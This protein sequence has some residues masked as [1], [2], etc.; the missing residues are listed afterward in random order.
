M[1]VLESSAVQFRYPRSQ[2]R[3]VMPDLSLDAGRSLF[4]H[5]PSGSGKT[6]LLNLCAG[7]LTPTAGQIQVVG[8][9]ISHLPPAARDRV[10]VDHIGFVF[11]QFNLLP[12]LS[13]LDNVCLPC[14]FSVRRRQQL[15][16]QN[17]KTQALQ[18][19]SALGMS[20]WARQPVHA[21]SVGQQQR[22]AVARALLGAPELLI[23]D[24]PTS[25][26][27]DHNRAQFMSLLFEQ[28]RIHNTAV[29]MVS[30]DLRLAQHFDS[31]LA[32]PS[33]VQGEN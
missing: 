9:P 2:L 8:Q 3:W 23:A 22:V 26:L 11:Q 27:D 4:I 24:E 12:Y 17:P 15:Q 28:A 5:G 14:Q 10:R 1:K 7:V 20:N 18:L 30:H 21:L 33:I 16:G 13:V 25:A 29:V 6:T 31:T 32:L 19:L